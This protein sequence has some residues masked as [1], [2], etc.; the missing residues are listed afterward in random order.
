MSAKDSAVKP[1][2]AA[3]RQSAQHVVHA[4]KGIYL[5][6]PDL[7]L[8]AGDA[9]TLVYAVMSLDGVDRACGDGELYR[10]KPRELVARLG[11]ARSADPGE[12]A[13]SAPERADDAG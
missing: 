13:D 12:D 3:A 5:P 9:W 1:Q 11:T 6:N 8:R 7:R 10:P 2:D 4:S